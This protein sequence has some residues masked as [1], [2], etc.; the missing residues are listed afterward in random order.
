MKFGGDLD[1]T[2]A[3]GYLI[4]LIHCCGKL[5]LLERVVCSNLTHWAPPTEGGAYSFLCKPYRVLVCVRNHM[6]PC[7]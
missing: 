2:L 1:E 7:P 5:H 3:Q 4:A 6:A